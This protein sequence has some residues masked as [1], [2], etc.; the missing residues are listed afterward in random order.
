[1]NLAEFICHWAG[2][3]T[4]ELE[5]TYSLLHGDDRS[6]WPTTDD[7]TPIVIDLDRVVRFNPHHDDDKTTVELAGGQCHCLVITYKSFRQIM[8]A[9]YSIT[10]FNQKT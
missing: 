8:H 6:K 2:N 10:T 1:M 7:S 9:K 5:Q 4:P 3:Y